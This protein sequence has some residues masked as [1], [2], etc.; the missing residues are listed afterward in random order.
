MIIT[1]TA[2]RPIVDSLNDMVVFNIGART[3][4]P[5]RRR[6]GTQVRA[7]DR[8]PYSQLDAIEHRFNI[9]TIRLQE[10]SNNTL[11][12]FEQFWDST[13]NMETFSIDLRNSGNSVG[14]RRVDARMSERRIM[15]T[16]YLRGSF[17]IEL[18]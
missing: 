12:M 10:G 4:N 15:R 3:I 1:Y 5:S 16:I 7:L 17:Q 6:Y 8:T 13:A 18:L 14:A 9:T 11:E 2:T